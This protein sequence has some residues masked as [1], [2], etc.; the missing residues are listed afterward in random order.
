[1]GCVAGQCRQAARAVMMMLLSVQGLPAAQTAGLLECHSATVRR[2]IG[3][4]SAE[5]WP[6][7]PTGR[8]AAIP[9]W[10]ASG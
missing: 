1:M 5:G 8:A 7:W 4:F 2:W 3:R 10:A 9:R 6:G